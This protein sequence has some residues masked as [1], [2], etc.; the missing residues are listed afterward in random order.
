[1]QKKI[2]FIG[3]GNMGGA[4]ITALAKEYKNIIV[5]DKNKDKLLNFERRFN[6]QTTSDNLFLAHTSEVIILAVKPQV[7][8][9]VLSEIKKHVKNKLII[10][11]AAGIT[12][13]HM[14]KILGDSLRIIRCM[15]NLGSMVG[16]GGTGYFMNENCTT[17]DKNTVEF[18]F[19]AAGVV[20]EAE[21][22]NV[23]TAISVVGCKPG[24]IAKEME[25]EEK[26]MIQAGLNSEDYR[27]LTAN[28]LRAVAEF[29]DRGADYDKLYKQVASPGGLTEAGH[30]YAEKIKFY[31]QIQERI[32]VALKKDVELGSK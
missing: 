28:I 27:K 8:D 11:I 2:G 6:I 30:L 25:S 3:C 14:E 29:I 21:N 17:L 12:M 4:I 23:I 9:N 26:A 15:P 10:S 7:M 32:R 19:E 16:I 22:E 5:S 13:K 24:W 20:V 31:E 18:I 1:M